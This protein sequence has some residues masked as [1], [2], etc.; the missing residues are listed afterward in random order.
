MKKDNEGEKIT[1]K[2]KT[3]LTFKDV[4]KKNWIFIAVYIV[5]IVL[6]V[7]AYTNVDKVIDNLITTFDELGQVF[8]NSVTS[9]IDIYR[10][11][12]GRGMIFFFITAAVILGVVGLYY[13]LTDKLNKHKIYLIV[14]NA[15]AA[16]EGL[17]L[18][19]IFYSL[20]CVVGIVFSALLKREVLTKEEKLELKKESVP[21]KFKQ[22]KS[23]V[24]VYVKSAIM[25]V[26]YFALMFLP[27][28]NLFPSS[29]S[30][31]IS[32]V[33]YIILITLSIWFYFAEYKQM[34]AAFKNFKHKVGFI[35]KKWAI[36]FALYAPF[37]LVINLFFG[38]AENQTS[39]NAMNPFFIIVI[40]TLYAPLVEE[41]VFRGA[42]R[43]LIKNDIIYIIVSAVA[44]GLVHTIGQEVN[45]LYT[46][47]KAVPYAIM[48]GYMA[49]IYT[50]NN[51]MMYNISL[52]AT[53]NFLVSIPGIF[54][55]FI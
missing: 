27:F 39:L 47:A 26:A 35:F 17:S 22:K 37:S 5:Q 12:T 38:M 14:T 19:S 45:L 44:F 41:T 31:A 33:I 25:I 15:I 43:K 21:K 52:H 9:F 4:L 18:I 53:H 11:S 49:Y 32:I 29:W 6:S 36:M 48:G 34:F 42:I 40:A 24:D 46:L 50:K 3:K 28:E 2:K 7:I 16:E 23:T 20:V 10:S 51:N 54:G 30:F 55:Y 1:K 8:G 13:A